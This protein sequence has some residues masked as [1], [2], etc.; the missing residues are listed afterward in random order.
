MEATSND[1]NITFISIKCSDIKSKWYGESEQNI[2]AIF[3]KAKKSKRAIIF[4]DE[5]KDI[6]AKRTD[7]GNNCN[8]DLAP[9]ILAEMKAL[10]HQQL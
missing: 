6:G 4:F 7:N 8:N 9:E 1:L 2:K 10:N 5:F 3:D